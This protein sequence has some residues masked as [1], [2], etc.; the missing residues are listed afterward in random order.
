MNRYNV[1]SIG[2]GRFLASLAVALGVGVLCGCDGGESGEAGAG[3]FTISPAS[4][5]NTTSGDSVEFTAIG[6]E[7]PITWSV[8]D[9]QSGKIIGNGERVV[10]V[11]TSAGPNQVHARDNRGWIATVTVLGQGSS[12]PML[13]LPPTA[14]LKAGEE[15]VFTVVGGSAPFAWTV[16]GGTYVTVSERSIKFKSDGSKGTVTATGSGSSGS[17]TASIN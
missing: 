15:A 4:W 5:T 13:I 10:Y 9:D 16:T 3:T 12:G 1:K 8:S 2:F 17:P 14:S 6:G 7:L 11:S